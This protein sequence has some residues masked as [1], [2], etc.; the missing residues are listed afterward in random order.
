MIGVALTLAAAAPSD[1]VVHK[2]MLCVGRAAVRLEP[3]G[4]SPAEIA[5]AAKFLC[6]TERA[7]AVKSASDVGGI[8]AGSIA[9]LENAAGAYGRAWVVIRRLCLKAKDCIP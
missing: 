7:A 8:S 9:E 3:S 4:E 6:Q 5:D 1:D 2:Y